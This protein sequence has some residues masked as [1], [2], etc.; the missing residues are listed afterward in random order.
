MNRNPVNHDSPRSEL[1]PAQ[2]QGL[3]RRHAF[4]RATQIDRR[5]FELNPEREHRLR[6]PLWPEESIIP[7]EKQWDEHYTVHIAVKRLC[8]DVYLRVL[9]RRP[10]G[11]EINVSEAEAREVFEKVHRYFRCNNVEGGA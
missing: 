5:F 6:R 8:G 2:R 10:W 11:S 7:G 9:V 3:D 1:S 4:D